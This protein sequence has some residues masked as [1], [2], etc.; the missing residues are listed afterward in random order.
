MVARLPGDNSIQT[1]MTRT[2]FWETTPNMVENYYS[3]A[4]MASAGNYTSQTETKEQVRERLIRMHNYNSIGT[5]YSWGG[6]T[7]QQMMNKIDSGVSILN[8]RGEGWTTGWSCGFHTDEVD[9]LNNLNKPLVVTSIGCG[10]ANFTGGYCFGEAWMRLGSSTNVKGAVAFCGPTWNT[11]TT[12]NNWLDRGM[13][14]GLAYDDL[15]YVSQA[16]LAG[17]MY[18]RDALSDL[19]RNQPDVFRDVHDVRDTGYPVPDDS[20]DRTGV[21]IRVFADQQRSLSECPDSRKL[22]GGKRQGRRRSFQCQPA[23][24]DARIDGTGAADTATGNRQPSM[25]ISPDTTWSHSQTQS[26]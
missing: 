21:W 4:V 14:R 17:K 19:P 8:F 7:L 13:Y 3:S 23:G 15:A 25:C 2:L 20:A 18:M 24:S 9:S 16:Y 22:A 11:H 5:Y 1:I 26:I 10:V 12:F 6:S